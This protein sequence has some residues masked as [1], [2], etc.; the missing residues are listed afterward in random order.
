M[1]LPSLMTTRQAAEY[2][3]FSALT[4]KKW[5]CLGSGPRFLRI[6]GTAVRYRRSDLE[7]WAKAGSTAA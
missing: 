3:G 1:D 5:R 6:G 7:A 4:L 2:L